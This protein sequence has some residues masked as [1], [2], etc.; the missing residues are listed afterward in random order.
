MSR[1]LPRKALIAISSFHGAIY[2]DGHRTG[3]FYTEALHPFEVLTDAGFRACRLSHF[4]IAKSAAGRH[5]AKSAPPGEIR[6]TLPA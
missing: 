4:S 5:R 2:P 1:N 6:L 3:L